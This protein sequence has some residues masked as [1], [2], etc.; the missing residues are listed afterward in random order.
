[1]NRNKSGFTLIELVIVLGISSIVLLGLL[2]L[3]EWHQK[4]FVYEQADV[5]VTS[6]ARQ[7]MNNMSEYIAQGY[8]IL[9]SRT[10]NGTAYTTDADTIVL[11][12][13]SR[14]SSGSAIAGTYDYVVFNLS[15]GSIYQSIET[16]NGSV[17]PS[18]T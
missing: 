9:S 4:V 16:G 17:R 1:M 11:Q 8:M 2:S 3:F 13:P 7:V 10:I 15:N 12:I 6:S 5:Q 18:G 14:N